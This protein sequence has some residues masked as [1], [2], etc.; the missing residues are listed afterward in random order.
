MV[1]FTSE[2][3]WGLRSC[4]GEGG[5]GGGWLGKFV[6]TNSISVRSILVIHCFFNKLGPLHI[7]RN[8]SML[9]K[10][11]KLFSSSY[12]KY[13]LFILIMSIGSVVVSPF[14]I[15]ESNHWCQLSAFA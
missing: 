3:N 14:L 5:V 4:C 12:S 7:S 15:P 9:F 11:S 1:G 13:F 2:A 6:S 10:F 8:L